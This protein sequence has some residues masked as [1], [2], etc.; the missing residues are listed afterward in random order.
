VEPLND[1][2]DKA[3]HKRAFAS[4]TAYIEE[5]YGVMPDPNGTKIRH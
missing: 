4:V 2:L 1:P 5:R 3:E